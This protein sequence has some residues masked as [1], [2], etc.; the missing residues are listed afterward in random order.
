MGGKPAQ[1]GPAMVALETAQTPKPRIRNHRTRYR[2][3]I[4]I[5]VHHGFGVMLGVF[6][7][8]TLRSLLP[9]VARGGNGRNNTISGPEHLRLA[10]EELGP[11][12]IKLGQILSSRSDLLPADYRDELAK[13]QDAAPPV[14]EDQVRAILSE[15]LGRPADEVFATFD[16]SPL[17][18]ASI[19][20]AHAATL[21]DGTE[22][23]V[24]LRR[25]GVVEQ[26]DE[27]LHMLLDL[28]LKASNYWE[29][30]RYYDLVAIA[31][32]FAQTLRNELDYVREGR[33]VERIA[34]NF[35]QDARVHIPQVYWETT[36][37]R[38]LTLERIRGIKI[39]DVAALDA[40]GMDRSL[41]AHRAAHLLLTMILRDGFFHADPHAGNVFIEH[42]QTIGLIDFGMVGNVDAAGRDLLVRLMIT[43]TRQDASQ[44]ADV[45]L[46][47]GMGGA[48][49]DRNAL[50]RDLQRLLSRYIGQA[51]GDVKFGAMLGELVEI[52]RR[53]HLRLPPDF[54]LLVK[55]LG[56]AEGLAAQVY[57]PF[58][59]MEVY[60]PL[61]RE[62]MTQQFSLGQ[63]TKHV[64]LAG[65]DAVEMSLELPQRLRRILGDIERGGFEIAIQPASFDPYVQ[66]LEMMVNRAIMALLAA[67]F[68]IAA[69]WLFAAYHPTRWDWVA[70]IF[71]LAV[72]L[73]GGTF[74]TYILFV[75]L[76]SRIR[77]R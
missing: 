53:Q 55:T 61:A 58:D 34:E 26:V 36:T 70:E 74:G 16:Y 71:F 59:L 17:A 75:L 2:Q 73:A 14:P 1:G 4:E 66:R 69:A 3:I 29:L 5:L 44:L 21:P 40:A 68:T 13:L 32:E 31:S 52:I 38:M 49:V 63:W 42:D 33:N 30:A 28:A 64:L 23:V 41:I 47:I 9:G 20:Q 15:E 62:L 60:V 25:P 11:T 19:G 48:H 56:M 6:G 24:K 37:S 57:P 7:R 76:S 39:S 12:F 77:R 50:R 67:T 46:E 51:I 35:V 45:V 8:D 10:L 65:I 54:A 22:V 72:L 43:M 27:D 18:S